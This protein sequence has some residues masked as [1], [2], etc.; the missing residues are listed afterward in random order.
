MINRY[1]NIFIKKIW[2]KKFQLEIWKKIELLHFQEL[3]NF[4]FISEKEGQFDFSKIKV[5]EERFLEIEKKTKHELAAFVEM[6][7][8][9]FGSVGKWIHY[10]LTSNDILDTSQNYLI[11]ESLDVLINKVEKILNL[12]KIIANKEKKTIMIGRTHGMWAEPIT[13]GLKFAWWYSELNFHFNEVKKSKEEINFV[14]FGGPTGTHTHLPILLIENIAKKLKMKKNLVATQLAFRNKMIFVTNTLTNLVTTF[15]KIAIE[16]RNLHRSEI[17][18]FKES[19]SN[20]QKGSSAMPH[21]KNPYISE[22]ICGLSRLFRGISSS[23]YSTNLLWHE[24]DLTNS[25]IERVAIP[26]LFHLITTISDKLFGV[27]KNLSINYTAIQKNFEIAAPKILSHR[28]L[29]FLI[30]ET[31]KTR[32]EC[33]EIIQKIYK[34]FD[35]KID[36]FKKFLKNQKEFKNFKKEKFNELFDFNFYIKNIDEIFNQIF[37]NKTI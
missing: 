24:R 5:S 20:K 9:Q 37:K 17:S 12:L 16:I 34:E 31:N 13:V 29:L 23:I 30:K 10:G 26:D 32:H 14:K 2:D 33:Y 4:N 7:S 19:F 11:R 35:G 3:I 6:I 21:K 25:S 22:N 27:I 36:E 28:L 15:E 8:E 1:E 18:E